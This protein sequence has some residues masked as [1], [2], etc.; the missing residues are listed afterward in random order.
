MLCVFVWMAPVLLAGFPYA[1]TASVKLAHL[2]AVTGETYNV[3][4][5]FFVLVLRVLIGLFDWRDALPWAF[6]SAV[7]M[8][9]ALIPLWYAIQRLFGTSLA[10][11]SIS[12]FAFFPL[13]WRLAIETS[14]YPLALLCLF[15]GF[16]LF[17][18]VVPRRRLA[19]VALLGFF[20]GLAVATTHAFVTLLPW[21]VAVYFWERGARWKRAIV[22]LAVCGSCAYAAFAMMHVPDAVGPNM[23][24]R[25]RIAVLFP[26][27]ENL[28]PPHELYG[29]DYAY[30]FLREEFDARMAERA[31]SG[32]FIERR[33]NEHYRLNYGVGSFDVFHVL[34]N[35][36][37]LFANAIAALFMQ[38]IVGGVFLWLFIAL[39]AASLFRTHRRMLFQLVGL[40][41][42]MELILR[43]GFH[44]SRI[45]L[46]NI[47]W[48][49]ALL[50]GAGVL[51]VASAVQR[52]TPVPVR[53]NLLAGIVTLIVVL[54]MGQ[55]NRVVIA[56]EYARSAVPRAYAAAR[57][58]E[59]LP[60]D[61]V[62]MQPRDES[63]LIFT[64]RMPVIVQ[65][66][67]LDVLAEGGRV[68]DPIRH[69][70]VTHAMGYDEEHEK[71]IREAAPGV[72]IV[73][74]A[75]GDSILLTPFKRYL[76]N[77]LR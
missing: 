6:V 75:E 57:A 63:L 54:Q 76:L 47:G 40:W 7:T 38:E 25:E 14:Y 67:T 2:Q 53:P 13:H 34:L 41:L 33:D 36:A 66:E 58:V 35:G 71:L 68:V 26:V 29:D 72:R 18:T 42:S 24:L 16:L 59:E 69:Y 19:A 23:S 15:T 48:I 30:A 77:L 52:T 55:A 5:P 4:N 61:A 1:M 39:G 12:I 27:E 74:I 37:W 44:Y 11:V 46:M 70:G 65:Q 62:I 20:F 8:A 49:I 60:D 28:L 3:I 31:E 17:V 64:E 73:E 10:W 51:A 56:K 50:A 43:F 9:L 32:T 22:E 21:F 45:H